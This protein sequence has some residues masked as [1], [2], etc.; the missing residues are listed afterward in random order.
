MTLNQLRYF[1]SV[2]RSQSFRAAAA[3]LYISQPSL[4]RSIN[5]LEQELGVVLF[6]RA[7]RGVTLTG[8]GRLFLEYVDRILGECDIAVNKMKEI[9]AAGE[10]I[11]IG[12]VFPLAS[13]FIPYNVRSFLN[14]PGNELVRFGFTQNVTSSIISGIRSGKL[15]IGFCACPEKGEDLEFV[16]IL[17]QEMVIITSSRHSLAAKEELSI[18][19]LT[20]YPVIGY[21]S[22][23]CLSD[24]TS[25]L[26]RDL[27]IRPNILCKCSDE[28]AIQALVREEFGIALVAR[29]DILDEDH[30]K[31]HRV[32]DADL[33][34]YINIVWRRD[35]YLMP[36]AKRFI[37]FIISMSG[38]DLGKPETNV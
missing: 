20:R 23:S 26:Y 13:F 5:S 19:E 1:Q 34:H 17:R 16:P 32:S 38:P 27:G 31:I 24:Y 10:R 37:D 21:D 25:R 8:N 33:V 29:A 6:D 12:Y 18:Q 14:I 7:V 3:E 22:I 30:L 9:S 11:D 15:D 28:N 2:A 36:A 35:H 4:S